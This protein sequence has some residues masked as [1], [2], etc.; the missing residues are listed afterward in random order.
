[1]LLLDSSSSMESLASNGSATSTS[2][3]S[4]GSSPPTSPSPKK[5]FFSTAEVRVAGPRV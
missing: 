2:N 4:K 5:K 1:M 3:F